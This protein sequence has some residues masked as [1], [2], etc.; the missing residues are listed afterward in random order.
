MTTGREREEGHMRSVFSGRVRF[1]VLLRLTL[2]A[3]AGLPVAAALADGNGA[4][5]STQTF[6]NVVQSGPD[7]NPCT[8]D[9]GILTTNL[10]GVFQLTI[11][12]SG[13]WFH[14]TLT[15]SVLFVPD[16]PSLPTYS[17]Q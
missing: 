14:G 15:G 17:G 11:N 7:H 10:N 4:Q 12:N 6:H 13:S 3:M 5:T 16:D 9:P 1:V 2:A 8:G